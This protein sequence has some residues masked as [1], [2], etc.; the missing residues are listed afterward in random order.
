MSVVDSATIL[1]S[2][3]HD[4]ILIVTLHNPPVNGLSHA[5]R[6]QLYEQMQRARSDPGIDAVV[7]HGNGRCFSAGADIRELGTP[8]ALSPPGLSA[9]VHPAIE[10]CGKPVVAALHGIAMGG[11]LETALT[12]HYRVASFDTRIAT[13]EIKLG[14]IP[15][16]GTQRLPRLIGLRAALTLIVD[17]IEFKAGELHASGLVDRIVSDSLTLLDTAVEF[18]RAMCSQTSDHPL[19]RDRRVP[20][21]NPEAVIEEWRDKLSAASG[22]DAQYGALEATAAAFREVDFDAGILAARRIY[23]RLYNSPS[24]KLA[25]EAFLAKR[26]Q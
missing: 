3:L 25:R 12:C 21:T 6:L 26:G 19:V 14:I 10:R 24:S 5:V 18:A 2:R 20:D 22:S 4:R 8:A 7:I 15:L 17:G 11:G 16:S 1:N 13:P 9:D 23:D